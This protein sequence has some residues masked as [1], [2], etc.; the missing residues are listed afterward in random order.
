MS[1]HKPITN[2]A[3]VITFPSNWDLERVFNDLELN[4]HIY[5]KNAHMADLKK[6]AFE[7]QF[8]TFNLH[9][10]DNFNYMSSLINLYPE[11]EKMLITK[12]SVKVNFSAYVTY[13]KPV[14]KNHAPI[15]EDM[16]IYS[17]QVTVMQ[18]DNF[19]TL[20]ENTLLPSFTDAI[21]HVSTIG[22]GWK[23]IQLKQLH[24]NIAEFKPLMGSS[25]IPLPKCIADKRAIINIHNTDNECFRWA[26]ISKKYPALR[27]PDRVSHYKQYVNTFDFSGINF[28]VQIIDIPL[29]ESQN[30]I[31]INVY[32]W[33]DK[34]GIYPVYVSPSS[35]KGA[36]SIANH[37]DLFLVTDETEGHSHFA[38]IKHFERLAGN[39]TKTK[40]KHY[41]CRRCLQHFNTTVQYNE[42]GSVCVSLNSKICKITMPKEWTKVKFRNYQNQLKIPYISTPTLSQF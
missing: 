30:S 20:F 3:G 12:K 34:S 11:I 10:K 14:P 42:H 38:W 36:D 2:D 16:F 39:L 9:I 27:N 28:P 6:S 26:L 37:Y 35:P 8:Q 17:D 13:E 25:F 1:Q 29:I 32:S 4:S 5:T 24:L 15:I 21:D 23:F 40:K 18:H 41:V 33:D 22:S 19:K 7:G 31:T